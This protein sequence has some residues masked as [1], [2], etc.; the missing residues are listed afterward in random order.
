M[1]KKKRFWPPNTSWSKDKLDW[2]IEMFKELNEYIDAINKD[3]MK[4]AHEL[5]EEEG[6]SLETAIYILNKKL[7]DKVKITITYGDLD[8]EE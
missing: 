5:S 1:M 8:S 3:I 4:Y 7:T 2:H 6:I